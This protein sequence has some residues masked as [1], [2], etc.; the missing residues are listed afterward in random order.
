M[1]IRCW[2]MLKELLKNLQIDQ[3]VDY[4]IIFLYPLLFYL[5]FLLVANF[6]LFV[7][8]LFGYLIFIL[9]INKQK[10]TKYSKGWEKFITVSMRNNKNTFI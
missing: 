10:Y 7:C 1:L 3:I 6:F 2:N 5:L 9:L 8:F 4:D